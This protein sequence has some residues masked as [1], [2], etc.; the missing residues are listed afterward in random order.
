MA[1]LN[2]QQQILNN[3]EWGYGEIRVHHGR[4]YQVPRFYFKYR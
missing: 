2:E 1:F 3:G 4:R